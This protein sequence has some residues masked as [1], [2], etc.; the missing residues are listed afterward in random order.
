MKHLK[1][2]SFVM[3]LALASC[4]KEASIKA[5]YQ[6]AFSENHAFVKFVHAYGG[7]TPSYS[8][9]AAG[10]TIQIELNQKKITPTA[11]AIGSVFPANEYTA[12]NTST[13]PSTT[14]AIKMSTGTPATTVRDSLLLSFIPQLSAGK[15]LTYF[16]YDNN[17]LPAIQVAEDEIRDPAGGNHFRVRF[18]NFIPNPP[19]ATPAIDV[20]SVNNNA[21]VLSN[22]PYRRV[23]SYIELPRTASSDIFRIRWAGTTTIISSLTITTNNMNSL[24]LI[25]RGRF[26]ATGTRAPALSVTRDR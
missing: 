5:P 12:V 16:F 18:A 20:F 24:T 15:Y 2:L 3:L 8:I 23:T 11:L 13:T 26:A 10:P 4:E 7:A 1:Y 17:D 9:P 6:T 22:I 19:T 14:Y 25:A 21:V